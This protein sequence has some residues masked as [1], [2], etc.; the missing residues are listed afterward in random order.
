MPLLK[1]L[2]SPLVI[3]LATQGLGAAMNL[4]FMPLTARVL[5]LESFGIV[6][7]A[8]I[9]QLVVFAIDGCN[10]MTRLVARE[11][12]TGGLPKVAALYVATESVYLAI[13]TLGLV[14]AAT[15]DA[16][17][18]PHTGALAPHVVSQCAALIVAGAFFKLLGSFYRGGLI[19]LERFATANVVA[20]VA[21]AVKF[22]VAF[23]AV[24]VQ[25]DVR[26]FLAIQLGAF[27]GEAILL[28][29]LAQ[30]RIAPRYSLAALKDGFAT[31]ALERSFILSTFFLAVASV[32][33]NQLDKVILA[34]TLSLHDYGAA[35]LAIVVCM[36]LFVF[37]TPI[38]QV[39]LPRLVR[40]RVGGDDATGDARLQLHRTLLMFC[41]P[42]LAV[43]VAVA[44]ALARVVS[45]APDEAIADAFT[46]YG[47]GNCI[48]VAATGHYLV[49]FSSGRLGDYTR[50][51][52]L[53]LAGYA[54]VLALAAYAFGL[55]GAGT[56]WAVGN[57]TLYLVLAGRLWSRGE[58]GAE[59]GATLRRAGACALALFASGALLRLFAP[60]TPIEGTLT[61]LA[62]CAV[63]AA[64]TW[65]AL[66]LRLPQRAGAAA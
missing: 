39:F 7:I 35:S 24:N 13:T 5:G 9:V 40:E 59:L 20:L 1:R 48:A 41:L 64:L 3:N 44:H 4:L 55:H 43:F 34:M 52:C 14:A 12:A 36:G 33:S 32:M 29:L 17:W 16:R 66:G 26:L 60:R 63:A 6:G 23:A 51:L 21:N 18:L 2:S 25:P 8:S 30:S 27:L 58:I 56:V 47:A 57:A 61:G 11:H 31:L 65:R 37:A 50:I 46:L 54:P 62:V 53:Y 42:A 15:F 28:R 19:G 45:G 22:P 10:L 49:F 38:H